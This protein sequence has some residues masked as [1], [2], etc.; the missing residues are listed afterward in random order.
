MSTSEDNED[1]LDLI[2]SNIAGLREEVARA[3]LFRNGRYGGLPNMADPHRGSS[4]KDRRGDGPYTH[5][6]YPAIDSPR[7][8]KLYG[9]IEG[10]SI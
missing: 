10:L 1:K 8:K 6:I 9:P 4:E 5:P 3:Q 7:G 2:L